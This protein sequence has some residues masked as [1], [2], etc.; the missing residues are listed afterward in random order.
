MNLLVSYG[1][2]P[3]TV[4]ITGRTTVLHAVDSHSIPCLRIVLEAGGNPNP[5]LPKGMFRSSPLTA[6]GRAGMPE[7]LKLLLQF[8]ADPNARNP[9]GFTAL[10]SVGQTSHADCALLLLEFGADL[11]AVSNN[12]RTPLTTAIVHNNHPVLQLFI[13]RC[14]E[15]ITAARLKGTYST[16]DRSP[17]P[18]A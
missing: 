3:N 2:D 15:Y 18:P 7:M 6:A 11:N 5:A 10:D 1:A 14:Y 9:E 12:G 13:D 16:C 17:C 8:D 4:D